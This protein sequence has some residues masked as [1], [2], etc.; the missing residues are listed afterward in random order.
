[1]QDDIYKAS[2][3]YALSQCASICPPEWEIVLSIKN[4]VSIVELIDPHGKTLEFPHNQSDSESEA[5]I[6]AACYARDLQAAREE[7]NNG[8]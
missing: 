1:M 8:R 4:G 2:I 7:E 3:V 6:S 5:M